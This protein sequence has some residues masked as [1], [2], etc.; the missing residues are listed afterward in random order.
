MPGARK[1]MRIKRICEAQVL[2]TET[3][4]ED[5]VRDRLDGVHRDADGK[6]EEDMF[7]HDPGIG[8]DEHAHEHERSLAVGDGDELAREFFDVVLHIFLDVTCVYSY[9][10][11]RKI[12]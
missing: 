6:A 3:R 2:P 5:L 10:P 8:R 4:S 1:D 11:A 12:G 7:R 9:G